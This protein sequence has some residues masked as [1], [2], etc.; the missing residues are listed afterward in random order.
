MLILFEIKYLLFFGILSKF[1]KNWFSIWIFPVWIFYLRNLNLKMV[2]YKN[3]GVPCRFKSL[4]P[5][6]F[7]FL[8]PL[9]HSRYEV[10]L[11]RFSEFPIFVCLTRIVKHY[12]YLLVYKNCQFF[13]NAV[14]FLWINNW[15]LYFHNKIFYQATA[16]WQMSSETENIVYCILF[17]FT[18]FAS[19]FITFIVLVKVL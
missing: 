3:V 9:S 8:G 18:R 4:K 6:F 17:I 2:E 7:N 5:S 11:L 15:M 13:I 10:Y 19:W 1:I 16:A 12:V 14:A